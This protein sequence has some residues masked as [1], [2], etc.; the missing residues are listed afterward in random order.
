MHRP[1]SMRLVL[2]ALLAGSVA[3][4]APA[5]PRPDPRHS[6][7]DVVG[8]ELAALR[9]NDVPAADAGIEIVFAFSSPENRAATGPLSHFVALVKSPAYRPLLGHRR[10]AREPMH[11][12][13]D[14]AGQRVTVTAADGDEVT[15]VF[16]LSRQPAGAVC[17]RCWMTDGVLRLPDAA[18]PARRVAVS[19]RR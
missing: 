11:T 2:P 9:D 13:G 8:F 7:D 4:L 19:A 18:A 3:G 15:Y 12:D 6:P 17:A 1:P 14:E 16:T 5:A 10:A